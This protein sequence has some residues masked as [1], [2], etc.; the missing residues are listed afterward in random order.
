M[1]RW[2]K[3]GCAHEHMVLSAK[4]PM[5]IW[6]VDTLTMGFCAA[7]PMGLYTNGPTDK[8]AYGHMG[9]WT[10]ELMDG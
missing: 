10:D 7:R 4:G 1:G 5:D 3:D 6:R 2:R 8:W 9:R